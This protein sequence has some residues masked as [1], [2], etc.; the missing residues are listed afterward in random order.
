MENEIPR[1]LTYENQRRLSNP[2]NSKI[3]Y[4][5]NGIVAINDAQNTNYYQ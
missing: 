2:A 1:I 4:Q 3:Q 5:T